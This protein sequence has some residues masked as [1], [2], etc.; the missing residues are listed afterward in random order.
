MTLTISLLKKRYS[1]LI[2]QVGVMI[3]AIIFAVKYNF[4]QIVFKH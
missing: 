1:T 2:P 4:L 3:Q